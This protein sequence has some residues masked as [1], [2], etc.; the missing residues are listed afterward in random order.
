[1]NVFFSCAIFCCSIIFCSSQYPSVRRSVLLC[2]FY[3][4]LFFFFSIVL[5]FFFFTVVPFYYSI[6]TYFFPHYIWVYMSYYICY[7][8]LCLILFWFTGL[9]C[10][11]FGYALHFLETVLLVFYLYFN[12]QLLCAFYV[13]CYWSCCS[14]WSQCPS[15][16]LGSLCVICLLCSSGTEQGHTKCWIMALQ[17]NCHLFQIIEPK[18]FCTLQ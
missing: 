7:T 2:L 15:Y 8:L 9:D 11:W 6:F 1:M 5:Q 12:M 17:T 3:F 14:L 10:T 18:A 4:L 13:H 16:M